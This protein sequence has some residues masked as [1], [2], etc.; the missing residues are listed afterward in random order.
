MQDKSPSDK[1]Q[2]RKALRAQR[3]GL[4]PQ[5]QHETARTVAG[6]ALGEAHFPLGQRIALFMSADGEV[7]TGPLLDGLLARGKAC[8][9]P[10]LVEDTT[11]LLFRQLVPGR[12]LVTNFYGLK[13]PDAEVPVIAPEQ[14]DTVFMP[15]VGFDD[16]GNRLGMGKGYYD[17]TFAFLTENATAGPV[18]IGLAHECQRVGKLEA[19]AWDVP[20]WGI[21]TGLG[22][23]RFR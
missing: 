5:V 15:L 9:L 13:E 7:D 4:S 12:P 2:L 22:F 11:S 23:T 20:L 6:I 17:R 19:A 3:R 18:L 1:I 21:L 14:L 10:V 16:S 8:Y